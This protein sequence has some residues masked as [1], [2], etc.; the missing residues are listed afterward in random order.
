MMSLQLV[1]RP[2]IS[3]LLCI[4]SMQTLAETPVYSWRISDLARSPQEHIELKDDQNKLLHTISAKQ[5]VYL[6]AAMSSIAEKSEIQAEFIIVNGMLPNAFAGMTED[7]QNFVAINFAMLNILGTD[8]DMAAAL[9]GHELAHLKLNHGEKTR[10]NIELNRNKD[11]SAASTRYSRDNER[12]ADYLGVIWVVE[13]GYNPKGAVAL[14]EELYQH[15]KTISDSFFNASHPSSIE[16]IT[17]LK[18]LVRRLSN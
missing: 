4:I 6:Y 11:F 13:A 15:S 10:A 9:I 18:S 8:L 3:L 16:R 12:E 5:M 14:Q 7:G 17:V 1:N 2:F